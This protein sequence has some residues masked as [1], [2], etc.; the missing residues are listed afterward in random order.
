ML[1]LIGNGDYFRGKNAIS[2]ISSC[3]N[4]GDKQHI[5]GE[6]TNLGEMTRKQGRTD[7]MMY[8]ETV[9]LKAARKE[10]IGSALKLFE[11]IERCYRLME[12]WSERCDE[13]IKLF[14]AMKLSTDEL[15]KFPKYQMVEVERGIANR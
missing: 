14:E 4:F 8:G 12:P 15:R 10:A 9:M 7:G 6:S 3:K 13:V 11:K 2:I 1:S 5:V